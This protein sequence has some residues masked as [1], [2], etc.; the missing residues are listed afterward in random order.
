M[1][2]HFKKKM[3]F[4]FSYHNN[5]YLLLQIHD[6]QIHSGS[7]RLQIGHKTAPF[8]IKKEFLKM[9]FIKSA[10]YEI[11]GVG[12]LIDVH[13]LSTGEALTF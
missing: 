1:L 12:F 13:L 5:L 9:S 4:Y 11:Y 2:G 7:G 6:K 10:S 3:I 8:Y